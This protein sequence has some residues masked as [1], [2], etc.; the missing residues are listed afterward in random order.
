VLVLSQ[1]GME[2]KKTEWEEKTSWA[3]MKNATDNGGLLS[4]V[5][6]LLW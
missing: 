4:E 6:Q 1:A 3:N 5:L 2:G